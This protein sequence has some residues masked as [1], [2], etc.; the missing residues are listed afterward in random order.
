LT[1]AVCTDNLYSREIV[2]DRK[3]PPVTQPT[4]L[5]DID[6]EDLAAATDLTGLD[7]AEDIEAEIERILG[8]IDQVGPYA[9]AVGEIRLQM[10]RAKYRAV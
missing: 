5:H 7:T 10:L 8:L 3:D 1:G 6:G 2:P 4:N 9:Q